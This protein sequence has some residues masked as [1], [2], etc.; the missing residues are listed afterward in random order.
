MGSDG[1]TPGTAVREVARGQMDTILSTW[2]AAASSPTT[3]HYIFDPRMPKRFYVYP[4]SQAGQ[5]LEILYAA[6]PTD[7]TA[8]QPIWLDDIY[9]EPLLDALLYRAYSKDAEIP[10]AAARAVAHRQAMENALGLKAQAD[11]ATSPAGKT[12]A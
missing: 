3:L 11:A 8:G 6:N 4:P 10:E 5:R 12:D 9:A 2:H 7:V 1:I